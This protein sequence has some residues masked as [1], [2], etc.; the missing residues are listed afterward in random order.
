MNAEKAQIILEGMLH[1]TYVVDRNEAHPEK[2]LSFKVNES[3]DRVTISTDFTAFRRHPLSQFEVEVKRYRR[4]DEGP[5][6]TPV[7]FVRSVVHTSSPPTK[8]KPSSNGSL[9]T[10]EQERLVIEA[11]GPLVHKKVSANG[12][13]EQI[14]KY[15]IKERKALVSVRTD[16][17]TRH[18]DISDSIGKELSEFYILTKRND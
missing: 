14:L 12:Q 7:S 8:R 5:P 10:R 16:C 3:Q 2:I 15:T 18:H 17:G 13:I 6:V 4:P 9:I 1:Q 11:L